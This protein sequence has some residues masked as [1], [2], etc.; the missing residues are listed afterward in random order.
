MFKKLPKENNRLIWPKI[1]PIRDVMILK[2][3]SLKNL[4][5]FFAF[6]AQTTV[7]FCKKRDH[8]IGF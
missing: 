8:N 7:S 1:R 5:N 6:F 2:I 4:P 3:L